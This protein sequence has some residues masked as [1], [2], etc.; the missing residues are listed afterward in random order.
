MRRW[1]FAS[2]SE[3]PPV[4][5]EKFSVEGN[6]GFTDDFEPMVVPHSLLLQYHG[7]NPYSSQL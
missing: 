7:N 3:K 5:L 2:A 4:T 1:W 6:L